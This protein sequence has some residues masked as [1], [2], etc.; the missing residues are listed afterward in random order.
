MG[1]PSILE[2]LGPHQE[3]KL[4]L[5]TPGT[6]YIPDL[7]ITNPAHADGLSQ[8]DSHMRLIKS[9]LKNTFPNFTAA[10]LTSTQAQIDTAVA[11]MIATLARAGTVPPGFIGDFAGTT[12]PTGWLECNSASVLR[13]D[14]PDLFT[15]I[16]TTWGAAD[17]THFTLPPDRYRVGR[18]AAVV[19]VGTLQASQNKTHTHTGS[20]T[21]GAADRSLDHLHAFTG[22]TGAMNSNQTHTHTS[23]A[24]RNIGPGAG[25]G[26]WNSGGFAVGQP[27][28]IDAANIDH[29]HNF[30]GATGGIDRT[31]DHLHPFSFTSNGGSADGA[32]A[33]PLTAVFMTCIKT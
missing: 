6:A 18:N 29:T 1:H 17:A 10:A 7:V 14:Y 16:G 2:A 15:A 20:G 33:R 3:P 27:A 30:S 21:T 28:A 8:A 11:A 26:N 23:N 5:E 13:A 19:A 22:T 24:I 12:V 25:T 4:P 31:I 9:A 32:E